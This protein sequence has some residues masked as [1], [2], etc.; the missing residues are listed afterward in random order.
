M[1]VTTSLINLHVRNTL[2]NIEKNMCTW[3][4]YASTPRQDTADFCNARK[5]GGIIHHKNKLR[6]K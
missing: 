2:K 6:L 1:R 5:S 4:T 3:D